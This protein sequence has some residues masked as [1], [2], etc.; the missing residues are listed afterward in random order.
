MHNN[1][2]L[3]RTYLLGFREAGF[4]PTE[5]DLAF[6]EHENGFFQQLPPYVDED[7]TQKANAFTDEAISITNARQVYTFLV[8]FMESEYGFSLSSQ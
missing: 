7:F 4:Q 8:Q 3:L 1:F 6:I 2:I 5:G